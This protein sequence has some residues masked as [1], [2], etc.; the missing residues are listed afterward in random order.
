MQNLIPLHPRRERF[1]TPWMIA[2]VVLAAAIAALPFLARAQVAGVD[3]DNLGWLAGVIVD[4]V[5]GGDW[6]LVV[7]AGLVGA[8]RL[9]RW[10]GTKIQPLASFLASD[11]GGVLLTIGTVLPLALLTAHLAHQPLTWRLAWG[12]VSGAVGG[13]VLLRKLARPLAGYLGKPGALIQAAID[14]VTGAPKPAVAT[15]LAAPSP[16]P[17]A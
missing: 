5:K 12:S 7:L 13:F 15:T 10:A 11:P 6:Q 4:A 17:A 8:V 2:F 14:L 1:W 3:P 9:V 16:K